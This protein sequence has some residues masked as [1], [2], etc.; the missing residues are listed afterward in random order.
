MIPSATQ[1]SLVGNSKI[2]FWQ[3]QWQLQ[4]Y[5]LATLVQIKQDFS[6]WLNQV[7]PFCAEENTISISFYTK[8]EVVQYSDNCIRFLATTEAEKS[9]EM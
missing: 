2:T 6:H 9:P 8:W 1:I 4:N 7:I 5:H 3:L